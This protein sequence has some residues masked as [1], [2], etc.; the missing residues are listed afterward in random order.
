[1]KFTLQ[2]DEK[3]IFVGYAN[4]DGNAIQWHADLRMLY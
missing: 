2:I 4:M 1:M 3:N